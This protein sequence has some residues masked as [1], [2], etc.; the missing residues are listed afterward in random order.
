MKI[1]ATFT[2]FA[3]CLMLCL[4]VSPAYAHGDEPA[5]L[6][7]KPEGEAKASMESM[8]IPS[9]GSLMNALVYVA[10]GTGPHPVVILLHGFPGNERNLDLAQDM[11]RAGW[12]VLYFNYR[13][14]WG[15]PGDFSFSHGIEDVAAA[16]TYLRQ[17]ENA[18]RL[19][20][21]SSRIVLVGHSMGGFMA[22]QAASADP[23]VKG[24]AMISAAD[25]AG[26]FGQMQAQGSRADAVKDM[27]AALAKEGMAPLSGC[28]P[29]GLAT[30][31]ADH[32]TAWAF[33]SMVG[34][35]KDRPAFV[36]TSDDGLAP[37]DNAFAAA[38][39][40]AG[41][42]QVTTLHLPTDHSYSDQRT[43]L[44]RAVLQWLATFK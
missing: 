5:G 36:I 4:A 38:L 39:R 35:L 44:S 11:R 30:D 29:E 28:T 40:K 1:H 43:E 42:K 22:V 10:A 8:Q 27:G 24:I 34:A 17:P 7:S 31:L 23:A 15:T 32:A 20:L 41:D 12:D 14:S 9:H 19:R 6:L 18:K 25:M 26:T 13:G 16:I 33:R 37:A 2:S 21:D 3:A